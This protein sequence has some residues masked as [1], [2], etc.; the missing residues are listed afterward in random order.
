MYGIS[1]FSSAIP[2]CY[3]SIQDFAEH[4]NINYTDLKFD[5]SLHSDSTVN[6]FVC[7]FNL[8]K[9]L[10]NRMK[11]SFEIYKEHRICKATK[12]GNTKGRKDRLHSIGIEGLNYCAR[13]YKYMN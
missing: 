13:I 11:I 2:S 9:K 8:Q 3:I 12:V 6:N 1:D 5:L 4:K 7:Q 10:D